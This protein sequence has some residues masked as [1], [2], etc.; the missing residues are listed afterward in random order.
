MRRWVGP[1]K[2]SCRY[3]LG[4]MQVY[5]VDVRAVL[6]FVSQM[7]GGASPSRVAVVYVVLW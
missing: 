6:E 3:A 2:C 5:V 1:E 4:A 7:T